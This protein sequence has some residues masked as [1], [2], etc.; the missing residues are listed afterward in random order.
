MREPG[1]DYTSHQYER[2]NQT[3]VC[4]LASEGL[5]CPAGPTAHGRCPALAECAPRREGDRWH[6][7]RSALRGGPCV[8]GP[9]PTGDCGRVNRCQPVRSL[10][11]VRGRLMK[12][13]ALVAVGALVVLLNS[14]GRERLLA[15]GPLAQQHAQILDRVAAETRCTACHEAAERSVAGWAAAIFGGHGD[16]PTQSERCMACHDKTIP[17]E[18]ALTAH[19]LPP[20]A[21]RQVTERHA[22]ALVNNQAIPPNRNEPSGSFALACSTCHREHRGAAFDLTA[23]T[24][25][26]CQSCHRR[27]YESFATDHPDFRAWPYQRRTRIAFNHASHHAKHFVA[28]GHT[29]DCRQCHLEDATQRGQLLASYD[30]S[31]AT[32]HDETIATS[33]ARGMPI[34]ALPML[35][36]D[37]LQAAGHAID[38]WPEEARG[39]FDG[40]LPPTMKL[41]LA[42]DP[43]AS[44]AFEQLGADFEF[45]DIDPENKTHLEACATLAKTITKLF[46]DLSQRGSAAVRERLTRVLGQEVSDQRAALLLAGL[47]EDTIRQAAETW[48]PRGVSSPADALSQSNEFGK[49]IPG[50]RDDRRPMRFDAAGAWRQDDTTFSL[51]YRPVAHADP[52]LAGW[53]EL[54][55][56]TPELHKRPVVRAVFQA[57]SRPDAPGLCTSCHSVEQSA[58]ETLAVHWQALD[59]T[60]KPRT[61]TKFS[62]GPHLLLPPLADCTHCHAIDSAASAAAPYHGWEPHRVVGDFKPLTKQQCVECH[63]AKAAGDACQK[64]HHYHV[65][66]VDF[67]R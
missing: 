10:R 22:R 57:L 18:F 3:W 26:A 1:P 65:D 33:T 17:P 31:C 38:D 63:T 66:V 4:G 23:L 51:R 13:C 14:D 41:L 36:T 2:P 5:A 34:L 19:S 9:T 42:A 37:V 44:Q 62:H 45:S 27:R 24:N 39:D 52:V 12:S 58:S 21:L 8:E 6:C 59:P 54:L 30:A 25:A 16:R 15:P 32:C 35:D 11:A 7:N 40:Q 50:N 20:D 49:A 60:T 64:C 29:F 55:S 67:W 28:K 61:L 53:L 46:A 43:A 56:A 47:S 48:F